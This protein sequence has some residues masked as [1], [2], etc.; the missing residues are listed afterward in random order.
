M[1]EKKKKRFPASGRKSI[2]FFYYPAVSAES[3]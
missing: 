3:N 1:R 2:K